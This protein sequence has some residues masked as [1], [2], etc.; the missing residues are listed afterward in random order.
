MNGRGRMGGPKAAGP[1]GKCVCPKC[2]YTLTH[3]RAE[4][5]NKVSC[6]KCATKMARA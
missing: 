6:P 1:G 3:T 4:P 5:C 2:G